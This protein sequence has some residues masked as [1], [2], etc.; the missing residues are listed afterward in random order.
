MEKTLA[1]LKRQAF[2]EDWSDEQI[3]PGQSISAALEAK[4]PESDIIAFLLS[5]DFLASDECMKEWRRASELA[6]TGHLVFRV[7]IILR[8]CAWEDLLED[9]DVKA[10][11]S[12]GKPI[13][14]Y[15]DADVAWQEVYD[16]IK[17]VVESLR[18]TYTPKP[19]FL[20]DFSS[21]E[22]PSPRPVALDDIFVFPR[23]VATDYSVRPDVLPDSA[24]SS[25]QHLLDRDHSI[26]HGQ[27]K[28]G[29]TALAKH[30]FLSLAKDERPVLFADLGTATGRLGDDFLKG[31]YENQFHGDYYLWSQQDDKTLVVD[32][33]TEAPRLLDFV[34]QCS[35]TFSR[36]VVVASSDVFHTFLIDE[37]RLVDFHQVR[38]E[39]LTL[40]QQEH[41]IRKRLTTLETG[42]ELTDGLVD[43]AEDRVNSIIL[44]NKIVPRY[45][46]FVLSILQPYDS[47][48][49]PRSLT[50]TSYGH[51]YYVFIIASLRRAGI[52]ETDDALNSCFNFAEQLALATFVAGKEP[53]G[54]PVD[55]T[56]FQ[57]EYR[58]AYFMKTSLLNRLTH[59]DYGIITSAGEFK[60]AY[61]YY[62]FLGKVLAT[63]PDLSDAYLAE[64]CERSHDEGNYLTLLFAIHHATDNKILEDILLRTMVELDDVAVATLGEDE[65]SRFASIVAALPESVLSDESVEEERAKERRDKEGRDERSGDE[66]EDRQGEDA[67]HIR[68]SMFRVL[69]NNKILGQV[70]R[71]QY[72][73]LEKTRIEEI[74][75]TIADSSFRLVNLVLKDEDEIRRLALHIKARRPDADLAQVQQIL[76]YLSFMWTMINVEQAVEAANVPS[77]REAVNAVVERNGTPAYDIFGYFTELDAAEQLT[78]VEKDRLEALQKKH[79]DEFIKR[80]LSIRTQSYMNTH[81][82]RARI[83]QSICSVL[84]IRYTPRP[85]PAE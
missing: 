20:S 3:I 43:Q 30:I 75:E 15:S 1:S 84:G 11:P 80:V 9:D 49:T 83:E 71:N 51:C 85:M 52:S 18:T 38:L 48:F 37:L 36:V 10:L 72:G 69:K 8:D 28:S 12:D 66:S 56:A 31:L 33:M 17:S 63:N 25:L 4:L 77:I 70:L 67:E 46:F 74:V 62:F 34:A 81:R 50:I 19:T 79:K 14:R 24:I 59:K 27:D 65:T 41:L 68:A 60:T 73:K 32:N 54:K 29:K 76:R 5:P 13:T 47:S 26:I 55:F 78:T 42:T 61:M 45:P 21:A 58:S 39:P 57:K 7:P 6:S 53:E 16:G 22:L 64:L 2:L 40:T 44:S 82:S 35:E 23:L